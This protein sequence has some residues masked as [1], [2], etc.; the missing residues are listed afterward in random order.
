MDLPLNILRNVVIGRNPIISGVGDAIAGWL[1]AVAVE[2]GLIVDT[3][4]TANHLRICVDGLIPDF[5][6]GILSYYPA[7]I[8]GLFYMIG[9]SAG[10]GRSHSWFVDNFEVTRDAR[11]FLDQDEIYAQLDSV[12]Q[13]GEPRANGLI[14]TPH[15]GGWTSPKKPLTWWVS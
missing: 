14:S 8:P 13:N 3:S 6:L 2:P 7:A 15:F 1:G 4:G 5:E 11:K 10:T 9:F 12:A